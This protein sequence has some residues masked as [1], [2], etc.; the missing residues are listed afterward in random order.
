MLCVQAKETGESSVSLELGV[1]KR[2]KL[3]LEFSTSIVLRASLYKRRQAD[4]IRPVHR[5][6]R[7]VRN[8]QA[9]HSTRIMNYAEWNARMWTSENEREL[10]HA[11][12]D[13]TVGLLQGVGFH[14][15]AIVGV[16]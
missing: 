4:R 9:K 13:L 12:T 7:H 16:I 15:A 3:F 6:L 1:N 10:R 14:F 11:L 8:Y 5:G 2:C